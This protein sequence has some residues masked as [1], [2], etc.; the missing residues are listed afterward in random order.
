[1][2][3]QSASQKRNSKKEWSHSYTIRFP[4]VWAA[5]TKRGRLLCI[6]ATKEI[7]IV[8]GAYYEGYS[9]VV[10]MTGCYNMNDAKPDY[11]MGVDG[12]D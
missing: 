1:M 3:Y 11:V 10:P 12:N 2:K 9:G 6:G 8:D 5:I 7:A 4:K